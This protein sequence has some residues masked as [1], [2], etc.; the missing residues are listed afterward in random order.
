VFSEPRAQELHAGHALHG[1]NIQVGSWPMRAVGTAAVMRRGLWSLLAPLAGAALTGCAGWD[2]PRRAYALPPTPIPFAPHGFEVL[3]EWRWADTLERTRPT[4]LARSALGSEAFGLLPARDFR[5]TTG[6]CADCRTPQA[7]LWHFRD[8]V[9]AVPAP[10]LPQIGLD[11][12]ALN[13]RATEHRGATLGVPAEAPETTLPYPSVVWVAAPE[14]IE[15]A[16]LSSDGERLT[17]GDESIPLALTP[18]IPTNHTYVDESTVRFFARRPVRVRGVTH[19]DGDRAEKRFVARTIWPRD[20]DI[21]ASSLRL[22]PLRR[23]EML[24]TL[25]EAQQGAE[26]D[27]FPVRLLWERSPGAAGDLAGKPVVALVLSGAQGDD[28]GGRAGHLGIATGTF[29]PRGEWSDWL[30][31]N[32]YPLDDPSAKGIIPASLP[33]DNYL[34]DVNSG[35][36]YWRPGHML[37]AVLREPRV[38]SRVH[39]ALQETLFDLYCRE[40]EFHMS[41]RNS[42]A[43]SIDPLRAL[44]WRIP[45]AGRTSRIFGVAVYPVALIATRSFRTAG[46]LFSALSAETTRLLP[47]V[48]FEVAGHDLLYLAAQ[49]AAGTLEEPTELERMLADDIEALMFVNLPQ[50]PSARRM[51][52]HPVRSLLIYGAHLQATPL[53]FESAPDTE[54]LEFPDGLEKT[55]WPER[56]D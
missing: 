41:R 2:S 30:V 28:D 36:L 40:I 51:G 16:M 26:A 56:A 35:Q 1:D 3:E 55:C 46:D 9:V 23:N 6:D 42:T 4:G 27:S 47:R 48:A 38:A 5:L 17:R 18:P 45:P 8:E 50:V 12:R 25:V 44:G 11:T 10:D 19:S 32:F 24:G 21:D 15:D 31:D 7:V 54:L 37:V 49:S 20:A 52:T 29:G 14:V 53:P 13:E 22:A 33:M 43:M 34:F 39:A